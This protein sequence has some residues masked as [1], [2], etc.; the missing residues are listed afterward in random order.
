MI[1]SYIKHGRENIIQKSIHLRTTEFADKKNF[2]ALFLVYFN[3]VHE[4]YEVN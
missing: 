1:R 4:V 2:V 3:N